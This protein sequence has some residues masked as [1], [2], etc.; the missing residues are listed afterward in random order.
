MAA[1]RWGQQSSHWPAC[2]CRRA[3]IIS[4]TTLPGPAAYCP[5]QLLNC[6]AQ[7]LYCLALQQ[8]ARPRNSGNRAAWS[9]A[10]AAAAAACR[11][12]RQG[13]TQAHGTTSCRRF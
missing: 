3:A 11:A 10:G 13:S 12:G 7:L 8:L 2:P 1:S 6:L 4:A 9:G 5:A